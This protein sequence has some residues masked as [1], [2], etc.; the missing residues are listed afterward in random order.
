MWK[1]CCCRLYNRLVI[2]CLKDNE[3][4]E[5]LSKQQVFN[6]LYAPTIIPNLEN[7]PLGSNNRVFNYARNG[8]C[9]AVDYP[10]DKNDR[11][12]QPPNGTKRCVVRSYKIIDEED[13]NAVKEE[14]EKHPIAA[15]LRVGRDFRLFDGQGIY[16]PSGPVEEKHAVVLVGHGDELGEEYYE[17]KNSYGSDWRDEGYGKIRT[18]LVNRIS[19]PT[20]VNWE[21]NGDEFGY[22][23]SFR[24]MDKNKD[25]FAKDDEGY[26]FG[27]NEGVEEG[28]TS[29]LKQSKKRSGTSNFGGHL[30]FELSSMFTA[31]IVIFGEKRGLEQGGKKASKTEL[32]PQKK[33]KLEEFIPIEEGA[34]VLKAITD[35]NLDYENFPLLED[36]LVFLKDDFLPDG[37]KEIDEGMWTIWSKY[38][39]QIKDSEGFDIIDFPGVCIMAPITPLIG[40]E[41]F[42]QTLMEL[43]N[44]AESAINSFNELNRTDYKF[45]KVEKANSQLW[46]VGVNSYITFQAN[47]ASAVSTTFQA[48]VWG[49]PKREVIVRFCRIKAAIVRFMKFVYRA[50]LASPCCCSLMFSL[51]IETTLYV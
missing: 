35:S 37:V 10:F 11:I 45:E 12:C 31:Y 32:P 43:N 4:Q 46:E 22:Y 16:S 51:K 25:K 27:S 3:D 33:L 30:L 14:I 23:N 36:E 24:S 17:F 8:I 20:E 44:E 5:E 28:G 6:C 13:K 34:K 19:C 15:G 40:F 49:G 47:D 7:Y 41:N 21:L 39:Q 2:H 9:L 50:P 18:D 29:A 1:G 48:L 42:P 38:Y 26:S